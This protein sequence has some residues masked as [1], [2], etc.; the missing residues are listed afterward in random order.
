M[1]LFVENNGEGFGA[2][3]GRALPGAF[4][5]VSDADGQVRSFVGGAECK[6]IA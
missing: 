3:G 6:G 5:G 4:T 2:G 1:P